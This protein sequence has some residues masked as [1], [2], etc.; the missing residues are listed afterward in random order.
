MP[1]FRTDWPPV[2]RRLAGA[3][4]LLL[5]LDYDGTLTPIVRDPAGARLAGSTRDLLRRLAA[6]NSVTVAV[7]SGRSLEDVRRLVGLSGLIYAGNH[8]LELR[9]PSLSYLNPVAGR[10]RRT[11]RAVGRR[12]DQELA[13][14]A[15]AE[16]EDKV[17]TLS[18]HYRRARP[19]DRERIKKTVFRIAAPYRSR[20]ALRLGEGKMVI[21]IRPPTSWNKGN[22]VNLLRRET[23]RSRPGR[24]F[25]VY[26]G[27]DRT[28]EDAFRALGDEGVTIKVGPPGPPTLAR[29]RLAGVGEVKQFLRRLFPLL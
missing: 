24:I 8:G 28:D 7:I 13:A 3:D 14:V 15:G 25:A 18:V 6:A 22:A 1:G 20:R 9:G 26:A 19:P 2:F 27:D 5:C 23:A 10:S 17:L 11:L 29:Y 21:E 4:H 16:V 12:L